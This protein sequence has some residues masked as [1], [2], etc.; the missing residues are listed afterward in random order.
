MLK[1][2]HYYIFLF[3]IL[4]FVIYCI[5][6]SVI[7][8]LHDISKYFNVFGSNNSPS[9]VISLLQ[10]KFKYYNVYGKYFNASSVIF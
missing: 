9:S 6:S 4:T 5:P 2:D 7:L 8:L 1:V 3:L 10:A